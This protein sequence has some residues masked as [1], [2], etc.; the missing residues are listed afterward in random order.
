MKDWTGNANSVFKNISASNHC[1]EERQIEDYYATDPK[2]L[3]ML[4]NEVEFDHRVWEC[5]VGGG[6]LADVLK[7]HHY[8]VKCS[9]IVDRGYPD[10]DIINFLEYQPKIGRN[11][12]DIITNPPYKYATEFVEHAL[13]ISMESVKVSMLLKIQFLESKKRRKLFE[14]YPLQS[15]YVFSERIECAKNGDFTGGS[16][17]CYAWFIWEKG[18]FGQSEIRW[19]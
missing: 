4:L 10:T 11:D 7:N 14:K 1:D 15:V 5:A 9:D 18:W 13:D 3:E 8:N 17:V 16:A 2:A 12:R 19:L 6:H